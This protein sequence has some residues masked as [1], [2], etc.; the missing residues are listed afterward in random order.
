MAGR[1]CGRPQAVAAGVPS[2]PRLSRPQMMMIP[3]RTHRCQ[4]AKVGAI[5]ATKKINSNEGVKVL[6][7]KVV[8]T[9]GIEVGG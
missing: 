1:A 2:T 7:C 5:L 3:H 6:I 8:L 4:L 9:K